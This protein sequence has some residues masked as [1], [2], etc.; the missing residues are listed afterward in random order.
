MKQHFVIIGNNIP[1]FIT[2]KWIINFIDENILFVYKMIYKIQN[3]IK[4]YKNLKEHIFIRK[5]IQI[6]GDILL[7]NGKTVQ[8]SIE[9]LKDLSN[10]NYKLFFNK[11]ICVSVI[12]DDL[13]DNF[14]LLKFS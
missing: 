5:D 10:P 3:E 4:Y 13:I 14:N 9:N 2:E 11:N 12:K 1:P 8:V 6:L 7:L